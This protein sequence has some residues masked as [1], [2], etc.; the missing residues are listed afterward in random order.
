MGEAGIGKT[1][2]LRYLC[3]VWLNVKLFILDV[4]GGTTEKDIIGIVRRAEEYIKLE[5]GK[6][7]LSESTN[8]NLGNLRAYIFFDE[9]NTCAHMSL[10]AEIILR[11][12]INGALID[13]GIVTMAAC[14]PY[15]RYEKHGQVTNDIDSERTAGMSFEKHASGTIKSSSFEIQEDNVG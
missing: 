9:V 4:H 15:R 7:M 2:M 3:E 8:V 13:P 1:Y 5:A 12:S 6:R 14:N 10:L 11:K